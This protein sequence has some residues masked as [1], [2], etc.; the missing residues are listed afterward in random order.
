[1]AVYTPVDADQVRAFLSPRGLGDYVRHEGITQGVEN[2]NYHLFTTTG[3]YILTLFEKRVRAED[4]PFIFAYSG[5]LAEK[6]LSVPARIGPIGELAGRPAAIITFL[7]GRD[8]LLED[9]TP[10]Q[11]AQVGATLARMH[12]AAGDFTQQRANPVG[13]AQWQALFD[14]VKDHAD[15]ALCAIIQSALKEVASTPWHKLPCG[16][17]HADVFADNV[18]FDDAG[19]LT[20]VIDFYFSCTDAFAYD[21]AI[22]LNAWCYDRQ[23]RGIDARIEAMLHAYLAVRPLDDAERAAFPALRRAA[24]LRFLMTRLY[25]WTF[26]PTGADVVRKD[27]AEYLAKLK[28][29]FQWL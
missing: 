7:E 16:A 27:P 22:T 28:A 25:D 1:M 14:A 19:K 12:V 4:L 24:A 2:T 10:E 15:P 18:F 13:P 5:H 17:V 3:R 26:T 9:V 21:L 23:G 8:T 11:C 29:T 20:G 6:G